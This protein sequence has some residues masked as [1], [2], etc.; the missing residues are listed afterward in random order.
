MSSTGKDVAGLVF[1]NTME[2]DII[3][4]RQLF[5]NNQ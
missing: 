3:P 5:L 1:L 2:F 4:L